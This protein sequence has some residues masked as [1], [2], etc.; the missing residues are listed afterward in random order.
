MGIAGASNRGAGSGEASV[1][2]AI[3]S[4]SSRSDRSRLA[5]LPQRCAALS[6][7]HERAGIFSTIQ[8]GHPII[9]S[10]VPAASA[11][12]HRRLPCKVARAC[13]TTGTRN[14]PCCGSAARAKGSRHMPKRF[15]KK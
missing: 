15:L 1:V 7:E 6:W 13:C 11:R 3:H 4:E 10:G 5:I 2:A 9:Q 14:A 12:P 8:S